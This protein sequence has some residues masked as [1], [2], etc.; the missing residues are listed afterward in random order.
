MLYKFF[1]IPSSSFMESLLELPHATRQAVRIIPRITDKYFFIWLHLVLYYFFSSSKI[2][3]CAGFLSIAPTISCGTYGS[4]RY[5]RSSAVN[6]MS[7]VRL[8]EGYTALTKLS[9]AYKLV[10]ILS[11]PL[12]KANYNDSPSQKMVSIYFP[13][14]C[15]S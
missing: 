7:D 6:L 8:Q 9:F 1:P 3:P 10:A 14:D 11:H 12:C 15:L 5:A 4:S 13:H 2:T